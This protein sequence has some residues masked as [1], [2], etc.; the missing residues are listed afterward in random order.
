MAP[1][2]KALGDD[3]SSAPVMVKFKKKRLVQ[4]T[5]CT[6]SWVDKLH[7]SSASG[8]GPL[9]GHNFLYI[10]RRFCHSESE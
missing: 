8:M 9:K 4:G 10:L 5:A 2:V 6:S 3:H 1:D 7:Q